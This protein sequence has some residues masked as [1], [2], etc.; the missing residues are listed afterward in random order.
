MWIIKYMVY[1]Q[2]YQCGPYNYDDA[3]YQLQDIRGYEG[4]TD[5]RMV[6]LEDA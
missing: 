5:A 6:P 4:V 2:S 1:G 3:I